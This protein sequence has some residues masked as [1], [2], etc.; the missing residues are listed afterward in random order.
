MRDRRLILV[1]LA[2]LILVFALYL[3]SLIQK[4]P[5]Q[6][7]VVGDVPVS[8]AE[9]YTFDVEAGARLEFAEV[10]GS[11]T[12]YTGPPGPARVIVTRRSFGVDKE[13]AQREIESFDVEPQQM[14]NTISFSLGAAAK[15]RRQVDYKITTPPDVS[16]KVGGG[17]GNIT[18]G[19]L[20]GSI[21]ISGKNVSVMLSDIRG[22][23]S[24]HNETGNLRIA[25]SIGATHIESKTS[26]IEIDRL[27]AETLSI[28]TGANTVVK[29]S[30]AESLAT[31]MVNKGDLTLTRFR[32]QTLTTEVPSGQIRINE[33]SAQEMDL[34]TQAGLINLF[35]VSADHSRAATST[36]NLVMDQTQGS[37]EIKTQNGTV[38]L[39]EANATG[40]DITASTGNV[41]FQGALPTDGEH[42]ITTSSGSI[43][44]FVVKESAFQ[45]DASTKGS[46]T[47]DPPFELESAERSPGHLR[48]TINQGTMLLMLNSA[49][50]D[51]TI[52]PD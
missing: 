41:T 28:V 46:I 8:K 32:A 7:P 50:G 36:G 43:F 40:L 49:S 39:T 25:D 48:G 3:P 16:A 29:D 11:I 44:I 21:E 38:S 24:I 15:P 5:E 31:F 22:A 26:P 27:T 33:S 1:T 6:A 37:F 20:K 23:I 30:G 51:I 2:L 19:G 35:R 10:A 4:R 34:K 14:G 42:S 52:S 18:I 47:V 12:I 13:S 45:L 9:E 17:N